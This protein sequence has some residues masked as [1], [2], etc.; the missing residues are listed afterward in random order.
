[1]TV[2]VGNSI[3]QKVAALFSYVTRVQCVYVC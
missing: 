1:M 2:V 3:A